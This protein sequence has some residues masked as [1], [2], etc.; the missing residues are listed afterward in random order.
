MGDAKQLFIK[1]S[2]CKENETAFKCL[3]HRQSMFGVLQRTDG[4]SVLPVNACNPL[5]CVF[6]FSEL[7][8]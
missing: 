1:M 2:L 6:V 8:C 4:A 5:V 7:P 3:C